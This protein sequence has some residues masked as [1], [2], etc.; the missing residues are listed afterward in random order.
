MFSAVAVFEER[1]NNERRGAV[2][3]EGLLDGQKQPF[4][5][6]YQGGPAGLVRTAIALSRILA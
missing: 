5:L 6:V 2:R 1:Q 3:L 4:Y